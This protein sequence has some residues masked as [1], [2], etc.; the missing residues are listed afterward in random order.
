MFGS[1]TVADPFLPSL[2]VT[3]P[4]LLSPDALLLGGVDMSIIV[5]ITVSMALI[6]PWFGLIDSLVKRSSQTRFSAMIGW[7]SMLVLPGILF[8]GNVWFLLIPTGVVAATFY[9]FAPTGVRRELQGDSTLLFFS[10]NLSVAVSGALAALALT[11]F[12]FCTGLLGHPEDFP[13]HLWWA[14]FVVPLVIGGLLAFVKKHLY[15]KFPEP[16]PINFSIRPSGLHRMTV[17]GR[18]EIAAPGGLMLDELIM[19][20]LL[21]PI[22]WPMLSSLLPAWTVVYFYGMIILPTLFIYIAWSTMQR[23]FL[24]WTGKVATQQ[25]KQFQAYERLV[26]HDQLGPWL[27]ELTIDYDDE[28]DGFVVNGSIPERHLLVSLRQILNEVGGRIDTSGVIVD[29]TIA[30]NPWFEL[31]FSRQR[32]GERE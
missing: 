21:T 28:T 13:S 12:L 3:S 2:K 10:H 26:F 14:L 1:V 9:Y 23:A 20:I 19:A 27:G 8:P 24:R 22:I 11:L 32:A 16:T 7:A 31:A 17:P 18:K 29:K 25:L 30:P 6:G 5:N 15:R 4:P